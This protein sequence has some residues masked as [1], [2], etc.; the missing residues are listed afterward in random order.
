LDTIGPEGQSRK[1]LDTRK[2]NDK[3]R[4]PAKLSIKEG[5]QRPL[6]GV[7]KSRIEEMI[8]LLSFAIVT[9]VFATGPAQELEQYLKS[10]ARKV[11]F[12]GHPFSYLEDCRSFYR[13]YAVGRMVKSKTGF[14]WN[15]PGPLIYVK[16]LCHT[17]LWILSCGH[18]FDV[19]I[20]A[21]NLN[22]FA[23]ILL[24]HIG[25]VNKVVFYTIDYVPQRFRNTVLNKVYHMLDRFCVR[26]CN[27][28]WNLSA[29]MITE[30]ERKGYMKGSHASQVIVPIGTHFTQI[31]RLPF[32]KINRRHL[33]YL[34][35]FRPGQ[36]LKLIMKSIPVI[37]KTVPDAKLILVGT[38]PMEDEL[39]RM[40]GD[41]GIGE[42]VKFSGFI[43]DHSEVER[44]LTR[45]AI[46]LAPYEPDVNSF[47]WYA[48]PSKPKQYMACGLPVIITRVPQIA[49]TI[50]SMHAGIAIRYSEEALAEAAIKLLTDDEFFQKCREKAIKL[51]SEFEWDTIFERALMRVLNS[52]IYSS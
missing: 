22:A 1:C 47:T 2:A 39:A 15:L 49:D 21:D 37:M 25:R 34:G 32:E 45:C 19:Y 29:A 44:I 36:G 11:V 30:R 20:G 27:Y 17:V 33:V 52:H 9:H 26:H 14:L 7:L 42:N 16:D 13:E 23:G 51:A 5:L 10:R 8:E 38:G 18:A 35:H 46:G 41:L 48:D 31:K 3:S 24:R 12:I 28:V 43:K 50:E 6:I 4:F 40:A